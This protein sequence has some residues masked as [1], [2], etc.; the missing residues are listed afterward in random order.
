MVAWLAGV[1]VDSLG[2]R[3]FQVRLMDGRTARRHLDDVRSRFSGDVP[4]VLEPSDTD[5]FSLPGEPEPL[6]AAVPE[7]EVPEPAQDPEPPH[8]EPTH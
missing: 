7:V 2:S 4:E 6:P 5:D 3:S 8:Q 1:I